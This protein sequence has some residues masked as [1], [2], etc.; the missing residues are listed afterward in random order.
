MAG[1]QLHPRHCQNWL[2]GC[3]RLLLLMSMGVM[4]SSWLLC[5]LLEL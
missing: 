3:L 1:D 4:C 2:F 5:C